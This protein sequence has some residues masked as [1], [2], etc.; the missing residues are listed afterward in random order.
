MVHNYSLDTHTYFDVKIRP[1][2]ADQVLAWT[3]AAAQEENGAL[4]GVEYVGHV[5]ELTN[6]LLY[7]IP[8]HQDG[9][10]DDG[11]EE[12]RNKHVVETL[13]AVQ[14]VLQVDIQTLRQRAKRDEL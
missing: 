8:K 12:Q 11:S 3:Q 5:G 7:R 1:E 4:A 9:H 2:R 10:S 14:G 6:H 13:S